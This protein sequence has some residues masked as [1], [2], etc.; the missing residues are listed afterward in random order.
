MKKVRLF[1]L[2]FG[3]LLPVVAHAQEGPGVLYSYEQLQ[4]GTSAQWVLIPAPMTSNLTGDLE[5]DVRAAFNAL[6]AAKPPTY[7]KTKLE[8]SPKELKKGIAKVIID[9]DK[10][11]YSLIIEAEVVYTLAAYGIAQVDFGGSPARI[12]GCA[13]IPFAAYS[14]TLPVWRALPPAYVEA[15]W[16]QFADGSLQELA[17]FQ[18]DLKKGDS[19][20]LK[21]VYAALDAGEDFGK[22]GILGSLPSLGLEGWQ[23]EVVSQLSSPSVEVRLAAIEALRGQEGAEVLEALV[24]RVDGDSEA[25][26]QSAAAA[27]LSESKDKAYSIYGLFYTA[28]GADTALAIQAIEEIASSRVDGAEEELLAALERAPKI[29]HAAAIGLVSMGEEEALVVALKKGKLEQATRLQLAQVLVE[30]KEEERVLAGLELLAFEGDEAQVMMALEKSQT[31]GEDAADLW[32][33]CL[34]SQYPSARVAAAESLVTLKEDDYLK[35]MAKAAEAFPSEASEIE[36]SMVELLMIS[37]TLSEL[38]DRSKK[39]QPALLHRA[40]YRAL[41]KKA[42]KSKR[43]SSVE[44]KLLVGL[45]SGEGVV[46]GGAILGLSH[47]PTPAN[48]ELILAK[49]SHDSVTVREDVARALQR[50]AVGEG[51]DVLLELSQDSMP[52]VGVLAIRTLGVRGDVGVTKTLL[53]RGAGE[54]PELRIELI[55]TL[56]LLA[57]KKT[58]EDVVS[59]ISNALFEDDRLVKLAAVAALGRM[60]SEQA[61]GSLALLV[62]DPDAQIRQATLHAL[63][64]SKRADALPLILGALVSDDT[65]TQ[66][67]A[68]GALSLH[69]SEAAREAL[70]ELSSSDVDPAVR[71][72]LSKALGQ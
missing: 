12:L 43:F 9:E 27:V 42:A 32:L 15:A 57:G 7:G 53:K 37:E 68:V 38:E 10:Q 59:Y 4:L 29:A 5:S 19:R 25:Q 20:A 67:A 14:L 50:F 71:A 8:V 51:Q 62:Q 65:A 69:G 41:G 21:R 28:R 40:V 39:K 45:E 54:S 35:P 23:A 11:A 22:I 60:D 36:A 48:L 34:Q 64:A 6:K 30:S 58:K 3:L 55:N 1:T 2:L 49:A 18:S 24:K 33:T 13:E 44:D 17:L 63:G 47:S 72:E 70:V 16:V 66:I 61:I 31:L 52:S 26:V 46:V 56:V